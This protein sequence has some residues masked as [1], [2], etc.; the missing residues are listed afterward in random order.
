MD[1][2][3]VYYL[4]EDVY[5]EPLVNNWY[6]WS[7]LIPPLTYAM[8]LTKTHCRLM[9]SFIK[10]HE[11]H[12][13]ASQDK[14]L[15]G[16]EFV[17]CRQDQVDDV[18]KLLS[19]MEQQDTQY[20]EI[21]EAIK[22]LDALLKSH[23]NG[24]SI[25]PLYNDV[26]DILKG[27]IELHMD[28]YHQP[29]YRVIESLVYKSELY[30]EQLQSVAFTVLNDTEQRPFVLSTPRL[31]DSSN[32]IVQMP[33][34]SQWYDKIFAAR[35][36]PLSLQ[37]IHELF[38][39]VD[40][41]G[42]G[43]YLNL[44]TQKKPHRE[45]VPLEQGVR[46]QY[47]GHAGFLIE[48]ANSAILVDPVIATRTNGNKDDVIGYSE[49]PSVIDYVCL[50]HNHSDHVS[51]ETLLQLRSKIKTI[52]VPK[53]NGGSL[54]DPSLKAIL[55]TLGF[56]VSEVDDLEEFA[57]PDGKVLGIPFLGEHGDLN[58]RSKT[59]WLFELNGRKIYT[60][61]DS[62]NL[63]PRMYEHIHKL[64]GDVD[65]LA[66]GMEC[67]GAPYTWIYGALTTDKVSKK[68]KDSRRLNGSDYA[69]AAKIVDVLNPKTVYIYA[70]GLESWCSY[71]MG[72]NY[73]SDSEQIVQSSKLIDYCGTKGLSIER[74]CNKQVVH[75]DELVTPQ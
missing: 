29:S 21:A 13:L 4:R 17:N 52:L 35:T 44:F 26:P 42:G 60:G 56:T 27:F 20:F 10:N 62:S 14:T 25:E 53:N 47:T 40:Y 75:L 11:L 70:L 30:N 8:Y 71:F 12:I 48:S 16:G 69:M 68:I 31:P 65:I 59:A 41:Q 34:K 58:I 36:V 61:A 64:I 5:V 22:K 55:S 1:T 3:K 9:N 43:E 2:N 19:K 38:S 7:N 57:L 23:T 51:I 74:L 15:A 18:A 33:F 39:E 73:E 49:L 63:E 6:A 32:I 66:I 50:T 54:A 46:V 24:E 67:V 28:L 45:H 37:E 72:I